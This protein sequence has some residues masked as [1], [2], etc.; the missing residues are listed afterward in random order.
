MV[1]VKFDSFEDSGSMKIVPVGD[2]VVVQRLE[3]EDKTAGGIV[4]PDSAREKPAKGRIVSVGD[5][6]SLADGS[7]IPFQV[8]EGDRVLFLSYA[9]TEVE[10]DNK[11]LLVLHES[12][13]LAIES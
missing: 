3:A 6:V 5:G 13:I 2:K 1:G 4:L 10:I 12:D 11:Q 7:R 9:G 8:R